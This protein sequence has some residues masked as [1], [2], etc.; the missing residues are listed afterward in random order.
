MH[1]E[2]K[3]GQ[4]I[5]M[6]GSVP[7]L[8]NWNALKGGVRLTWTEGHIWRVKFKRSQLP[9]AFEFKFV[10]RDGRGVVR[11]EG[12]PNHQFNLSDYIN[13]FN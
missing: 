1:Y 3:F 4:E 6:V 9:Q 10:I 7:E 13:K 8:S 11:W 12:N 2:T 5:I